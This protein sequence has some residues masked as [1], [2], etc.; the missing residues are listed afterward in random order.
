MSDQH[1][2]VYITLPVQ[3]QQLPIADLAPRFQGQPSKKEK[4]EL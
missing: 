1:M 2:T 3:E 4:T